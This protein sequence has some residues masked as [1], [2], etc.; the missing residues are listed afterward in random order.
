MLFYV[1][2]NTTLVDKLFP[3]KN[4]ETITVCFKLKNAKRMF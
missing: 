1:K 4:M 2:K 3:N